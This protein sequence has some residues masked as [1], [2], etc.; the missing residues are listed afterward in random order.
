MYF[1]IATRLA[2]RVGVVI[3]GPRLFPDL[4][5]NVWLHSRDTCSRSVSGHVLFLCSTV[6]CLRLVDSLEAFLFGT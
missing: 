1:H 3:C 4:Y 6:V 2:I 5:D